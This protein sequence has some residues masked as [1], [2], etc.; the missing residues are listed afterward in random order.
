MVFENLLVLFKFDKLFRNEVDFLFEKVAEIFEFVVLLLVNI[1]YSFVKSF[2]YLPLKRINR[3]LT[4]S[5]KLSHPLLHL[6]LNLFPI[7]LP[8]AL[9]LP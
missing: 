9:H 1:E 8:R 6:K 2:K 7:L 3:K 5:L 4:L